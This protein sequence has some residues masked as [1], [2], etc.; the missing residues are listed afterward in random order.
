MLTFNINNERQLLLFQ[1]QHDGEITV[2]TLDSRGTYDS[3]TAKIPPGD[4]VMLINYW[5]HQTAN[6]LPI[7]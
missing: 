4:M 2:K 7:F 6:D 3:D 5:R 1:T